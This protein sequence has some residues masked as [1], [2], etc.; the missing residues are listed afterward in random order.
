MAEATE[1]LRA[2]L[3]RTA[4]AAESEAALE[5]KWV[6]MGAP[7][8][9]AGGNAPGEVGTV[10]MVTGI[11]LGAGTWTASC[12]I[13]SGGTITSATWWEPLGGDAAEPLGTKAL[14]EGCGGVDGT[15]G[16]IDALV[17]PEPIH[18]QHLQTWDCQ[19]GRVVGPDLEHLVV[20]ASWTAERWYSE[21][22][23]KASE[24][25]DC[26]VGGRPKRLKL[27]GAKN[28]GQWGISR[29]IPGNQ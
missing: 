24:L 20:A 25:K 14:V 26:F 12:A 15:R 17:E 23:E 4:E 1:A 9:A 18:S 7:S 19:A 27:F 5:G 29:P 11:E 21:S 13:K 10:L 2:H 8:A 22:Q 3:K 6:E 16:G 28:V